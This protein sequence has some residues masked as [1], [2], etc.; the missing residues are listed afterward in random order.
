MPAISADDDIAVALHGLTLDSDLEA[1]LHHAIRA[2]VRRR[3][4]GREVGE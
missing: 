3:L 2:Q 4:A 1:E